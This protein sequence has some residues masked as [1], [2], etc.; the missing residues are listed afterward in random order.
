MAKKSEEKVLIPDAGE[1]RLE[2]RTIR[3]PVGVWSEVEEVGKRTHRKTANAARHLILVGL[4]ALNG[5][6]R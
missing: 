1:E 2:G 3:L 6:S 5:K 4:D